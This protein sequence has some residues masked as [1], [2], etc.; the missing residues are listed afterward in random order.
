MFVDPRMNSLHCGEAN[1]NPVE[2]QFIKL[3]TK[4]SKH[5][6]LIF[7]CK[8]LLGVKYLIIQK[9]NNSN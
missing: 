1:N 9:N 3:N 8:W 6:K 2:F 7:S 5:K 4:F